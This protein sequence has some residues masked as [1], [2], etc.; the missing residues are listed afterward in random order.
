MRTAA[1]AV[2]VI[3]LIW[4]TMLIWFAA[5]D[6]SQL[7]RPDQLSRFEQVQEDVEACT[8]AIRTGALDEGSLDACMEQR[9][10]SRAGDFDHALMIY[11]L[12]P[13]GLVWLLCLFAQA[14]EIS[15]LS[16][17]AA[18]LLPCAAALLVGLVVPL[19]AEILP[20]LKPGPFGEFTIG[21]F[22]FVAMVLGIALIPVLLCFVLPVAALSTLG[23]AIL[24]L[25]VVPRRA[26]LFL[27]HYFGLGSGWWRKRFGV[28]PAQIAGTLATASIAVPAALAF[29]W[30][31]DR[32]D[33]YGSSDITLLVR[34]A[35][36][37]LGIGLLLKAHSP[38]L[39]A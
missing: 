24:W 23:A 20:A 27:R 8:G 5:Y 30:L 21:V 36:T 13:L 11:Y 38:T 28:W 17:L 10:E 31:C 34:G 4:G 7:S 29:W 33:G 1:K 2:A 19:I 37:A 15:P 6:A 26:D 3:V 32:L 22:L 35:V 39:R 9:R 16:I 14:R 25:L 18:G 12:L